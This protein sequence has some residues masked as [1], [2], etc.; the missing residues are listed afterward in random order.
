MGVIPPPIVPQPGAVAGVQPINGLPPD[1]IDGPP[2]W[3]TLQAK[4]AVNF[5]NAEAVLLDSG[6][7]VRVW[8]GSASE[9]GQ[10]WNPPPGFSQEDDFYGQDAV[11]LS[12]NSGLFQVDLAVGGPLLDVVETEQGTGLP[13]WYGGVATQPAEDT[14][15]D[16]LPGFYLPGGAEQ[17][18]VDYSL[19]NFTNGST[20]WNHPRKGDEVG[21]D[22]SVP[23]PASGDAPVTG[24]GAEYRE[25]A[26]LVA[27]LAAALHGIA[28]EADRRGVRSE[29]VHRQAER[30]ERVAT[31]LDSHSRDL[32]DPEAESQLKALASGLIGISRHV[33][34]HFPWSGH[35]ADATALVDAIVRRA[36]AIATRP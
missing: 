10:Y 13:V 34:V 3:P 16:D 30:L 24:E 1:S 26:A 7:I 36:H 19:F 35:A 2:G 25:L 20:P 14:D 12:W 8:G 9:F 5:T 21:S 32:P 29:P 11:E 31:R 23:G 33:D 4:D 28:G 17:Y 6:S 18:F 22:Q 15:G 27:R